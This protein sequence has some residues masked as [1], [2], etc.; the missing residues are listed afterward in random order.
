VIEVPSLRTRLR[1]DAGEL[2]V[3]LGSIL[4]RILGED[5]AETRALVCEALRAGPAADYA[6]P[7]NVREL[8]QCVRR[9]L[10]TRRYDGDPRVASP[11]APAPG[12]RDRD[13]SFLE[14][15]GDATARALVVRYCKALHTRY[16]T[17]EE[18]AR[19]TGLDR[20]TVKAHVTDQSE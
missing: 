19:R 3:L 5:A 8:E 12:D 6:W 7:G 9:V 4:R 14:S 18:V 15:V 13:E 11:D 20:R 10:L 2:D 1:E 17:Y 16:G